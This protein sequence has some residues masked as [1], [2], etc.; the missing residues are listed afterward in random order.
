MAALPQMQK[1]QEMFGKKGMQQAEHM[2]QHL[3][4][5]AANDPKAYD[6]FLK[7]Q[8]QSA[9]PPDSRLNPSP[10]FVV[11]LRHGADR[12]LLLVNV[13]C[14]DKIDD[15][16]AWC[17]LVNSPLDPTIYK[18]SKYIERMMYYPGES[19]KNEEN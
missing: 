7:S 12:G 11:Q 8:M 4:D 9:A 1:L 19:F 2:W 10:G 16:R 13:C 6:A 5:M 14:H 15:T 17:S 3:D 18:F